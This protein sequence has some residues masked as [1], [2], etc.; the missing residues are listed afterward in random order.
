MVKGWSGGGEYGGGDGGEGLGR[1]LVMG[2][3]W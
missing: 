3:D 1:R 2:R